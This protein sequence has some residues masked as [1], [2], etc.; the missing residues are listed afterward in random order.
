MVEKKID[1]LIKVAD[2]KKHQKNSDRK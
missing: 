2:G 1:E